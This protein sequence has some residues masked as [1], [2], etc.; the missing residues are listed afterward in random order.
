MLFP[1]P[2]APLPSPTAPHLG[3]T[4]TQVLRATFDKS[5]VGMLS[6]LRSRLTYANA[7]STIALFLALGGGAYAVSV[8]KNSVGPKQLK[9]SAVTAAKLRPGSV[10]TTHVKNRSLLVGDFRPGQLSFGAAGRAEDLDPPPAAPKT[11]VA[12]MTLTTRKAGRIFVLG[13]LRDPFMTCDGGGC[14]SQWGIY[15]DDKPVPNT[16]VALSAQQ[17]ASDGFAYSTLYGVT[18]TRLPAGAHRIRIGRT[19]AG[20]VVNVGQLGAQLGAIQIAG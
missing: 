18:S 3:P 2:T 11:T 4:T 17:G 1:S 19:D 9:R 10:T 12:S 8:P 5:N 14:S 16:G 15:V 6:K 7:M 13:T 20:N